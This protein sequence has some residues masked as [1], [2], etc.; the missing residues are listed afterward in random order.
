MIRGFA[1][2]QSADKNFAGI[3]LN[4]NEGSIGSLNRYPLKRDLD[5]LNFFSKLYDVKN[6]NIMMDRG[7][8][9]ILEVLFTA[10][11][12]QGD[13]VTALSPTYGMYSI[14]SQIHR[15]HYS[16]VKAEDILFEVKNNAPQLVLL[17]RPNNPTGEIIARDEVL[18]IIKATP[19]SSIVAIDEAYIEFDIDESLHDVIKDFDNV[20]ILRTLSKAYSLAS[21]RVGFALGDQSL[22]E[23]LI[24]YQSPYPIPGLVIDYLKNHFTSSYIEKIEEEVVRIKLWRERLKKYFKG[25]G[26]NFFYLEGK[27][28]L[29][30]Y[31]SFKKEGMLVRYFSNPE[32]IRISIGPNEEM[33]MLEDLCEKL[34]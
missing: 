8:D 20:L 10:F 27:Q 29:R 13:L 34:L 21:L 2:Y 32:A 30:L 1:G 6:E 25:E 3:R 23:K 16:E 19:K 31:E 7:I 33:R 26:G 4:A 14:L 12:G 17:C 24:P 18:E 11:V 9:G 22:I 5:V 15:A 28:S